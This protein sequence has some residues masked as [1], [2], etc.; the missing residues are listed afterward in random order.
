MGWASRCTA[1]CY[2]LQVSGEE[3]TGDVSSG[4]R[5]DSAAISF[6]FLCS[7]FT[8]SLSLPVIQFVCN[9]SLY[10]VDRERDIWYLTFGIQSHTP[11]FFL[12][13]FCTTTIQENRRRAM[14]PL[15]SAYIDRLNAWL[16]AYTNAIARN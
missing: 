3:A 7:S 8:S 2:E 4:S 5:T 10:H 15:I 9:R 12:P 13:N 6:S 14:D 1:H 16:D 11:P